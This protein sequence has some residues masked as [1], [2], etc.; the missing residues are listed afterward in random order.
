[1]ALALLWRKPYS[2]DGKAAK[3]VEGFGKLGNMNAGPLW[4]FRETI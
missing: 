3:R 4:A 1:M 2:P